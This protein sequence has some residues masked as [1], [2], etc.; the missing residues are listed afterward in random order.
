MQASYSSRNLPILLTGQ[1]NAAINAPLT[2]PAV[3][4]SVITE[5]NCCRRTY[6]NR[7]LQNDLDSSYTENEIDLMILTVTIGGSIPRKKPRTPSS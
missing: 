4:D 3:V 5:P 7:A 6:S 2:A 1:L